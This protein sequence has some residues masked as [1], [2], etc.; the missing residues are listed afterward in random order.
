MPVRTSAVATY[1]TEQIARLEMM[2]SGTSRRGFLASCE[3]VET[4]S[5]PMKA[6]KMMP[7]AAITPLQPKWPKCPVFAGTNGCQF[8]GVTKATPSSTNA[9]TTE[10][11]S[12]TIAEL[13]A[14]DW[15]MP[16]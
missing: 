3:H 10:T 1:S 16:M 2:A 13:I 8:A 12:T 7:A 5:K 14:E 6:K 15:R 11:L 9:N 4:V